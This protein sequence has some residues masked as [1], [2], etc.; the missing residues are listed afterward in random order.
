MYRERELGEREMIS[1]STLVV[2]I[3]VL[4]SALQSLPKPPP[5]HHPHPQT[6]SAA[7]GA[8]S[9]LHFSTVSSTSLLL[10]TPHFT[11]FKELG[12]CWDEQLAA[13]G[14]WAIT[15]LLT[16]TAL[17][18]QEGSPATDMGERGEPP[19]NSL[20]L[21]AAEKGKG[22]GKKWAWWRGYYREY[23]RVRDGKGE[24]E[25]GW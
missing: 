2:I 3:K 16:T 13:F 11:T 1:L 21:I 23:R 8:V 25:C 7:A 6:L 22:E 10:L 9:M 5:P 15:G 4:E 24:T 12:C 19:F 20:M 17:P 18:C 14:V